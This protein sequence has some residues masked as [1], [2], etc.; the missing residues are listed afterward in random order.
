MSQ[1]LIGGG[2]SYQDQSLADIIEDMERWL[3]YSIEIMEL[4]NK[5]VKRSKEN[6]FWDKVPWNFQ[7]TLLS[8]LTCQRTFIHD[9]EMIIRRCKEDDIT[10]REVELLRGIGITA[11]EFNNKYGKTYNEEYRW[12]DYDS[13][14]FRVVENLYAEGR[15]F[16][17]TLQD[18]A[19]ASNRLKDYI[20]KQQKIIHQNN[21]SQK[22]TGNG[23]QVA[24]VNT[25]IMNFDSNSVDNFREAITEAIGKINELNDV[26]AEQKEHLGEILYEAEGAVQDEDM[27]KQIEVKAK[28]K[29]FM[30]GIG[31]ASVN[32]IS[33]LSSLTAIAQFFGINL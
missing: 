13:L 30:M 32:V 4:I 20:S 29:G 27:S 6:T 28:F 15:D 18:A 3:A 21:V 1:G 31:K 12:K 10:E 14:D 9:F 33:V 7:M 22:I 16:F 11:I 5:D 17:V 8:T 2:T 24:G 23:N 25:G 19:N 26:S